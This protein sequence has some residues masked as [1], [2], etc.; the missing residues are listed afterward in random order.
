M[1]SLVSLLIPI[2]G[3]AVL[4][5]LA[6]FVIHM[7]LK[8]HWSDVATVPNE[9]RVMDALRSFSI[10]AGDYVI[11][12]ASTPKEMKDQAFI[13]KW[14]R[15]PVAIMTVVPPGPMSMGKSLTQWFIYCAVIALFAAYV[16]S[17][18]LAPGSPYLSVFR[19]TGTVAFI[20]FAGGL[21]QNSIWWHR[22]W[23]ATI[24]STIDGLIYGLLVAGVFGSLWP[25]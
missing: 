11:P 7:V 5:F 4:V 3:S 17:R 22:K 10:P 13:E 23:S 21:W 1:V 19:V 16:A 14:S 18:T 24:K 12:H 8:Y 6:S 9:D 25:E 20:G 15:G 2:L